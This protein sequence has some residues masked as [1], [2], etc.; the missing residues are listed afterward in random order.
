MKYYK[1]TRKTDS[2]PVSMYVDN[3]LKQEYSTEKFVECDDRLFAIGFGFFV[4]TS[5]EA[6]KESV[7]LPSRTQIWEVEVGEVKDAPEIVSDIFDVTKDQ[8]LEDEF[9]KTHIHNVMCSYKKEK[10]AVTN[11]VKLLQE[12]A[13]EY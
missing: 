12:V 4:F 5:L 8:L 7:L 9:I 10:I 3:D 2:S 13:F 6:A 1:T 11:K